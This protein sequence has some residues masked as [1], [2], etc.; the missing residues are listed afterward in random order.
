MKL[1]F[2]RAAAAIALAAAALFAAPVAANAA[3][4]YPPTPGPGQSVPISTPAGIFAANEPVTI[5]LSGEDANFATLGVVRAVYVTNAPIGTVT[6]NADGSVGYNLVLPSTAT[7][8][9][10][11]TMTSPSR[12]QGYI[13]SF[14]AGSTGGVGGGGTGSGSGSASGSTGGLPATGLDSG[15]LLGLWVGGGALVLAGGA[16]AVG[17]AVRRQRKNADA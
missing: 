12:P 16:V 15:S 13:V 11:V 14:A 8:T 4:G 17:A 1:T 10:T 3:G 7:G 9:Y 2:T 5:L 6:S